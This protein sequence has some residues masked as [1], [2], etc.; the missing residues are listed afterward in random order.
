MRTW[1]RAR[2]PTFHLEQEQAAVIGK[3]FSAIDNV[4][5]PF[6]DT[7]I[8]TTNE[9]LAVGRELFEDNQCTL[10]HQVGDQIPSR[11]AADLAPDLGL[12]Y[13]RLRPEW[14]LDW[15]LDPQSIAPG[16][17]M[18]ALFAGG[19]TPFEQ[20]GGNAT[21]QIQAIRDHLFLTVGAGERAADD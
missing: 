6:I 14:V 7:S 11:D 13:Q 15:V 9:R 18:P 16:T 21:A 2:M 17:N 10:C 4:P 1:L 19:T 3:Y 20:L 8:E 12:A 5:Y